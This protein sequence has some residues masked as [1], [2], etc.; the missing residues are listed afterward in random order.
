MS[1]LETPLDVAFTSPRTARRES[2]PTANAPV[3]ESRHGGPAERLAHALG[4]L[5]PAAVFVVVVLAGLAVI[6]TLSIGLG[7]FTTRVLEPISGI[8]TPDEHVN[9]WLAAHRTP[10]RT[11]ASLV[12]SIAA[13]GIIVD[14][15]RRDRTRCVLLRKWRMPRS[16]SSRSRSV[17]DVPG[18]DALVHSTARA[19]SGS[20]PAGER[21][22]SVRSHSS[23]GGGVRQASA[24][25]RPV[26]EC[27]VC[28][29]AWL[30]SRW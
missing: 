6:A 19:C 12:G 9:T 27:R 7:F 4:D 21:E 15:R 5:H 16:W 25:L 20:A 1:N 10:G 18:H 24:L 14:H 30:W 28:V 22:L 8:G 29:L 3:L 11:D 17:G 26:H 13:G 2:R 23:V